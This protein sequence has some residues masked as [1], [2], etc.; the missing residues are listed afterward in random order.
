MCQLF[1][2]S[3]LSILFNVKF[4][5]N[6]LS[7]FIMFR[8][9]CSVDDG[10]Y[11]GRIKFQAIIPNNE[12]IKSGKRKICKPNLQKDFRTILCCE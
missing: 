5:I 7:R 4:L 1:K 2:R 3:Y 8:K 11:N 6:F 9:V 12:Q 10:C